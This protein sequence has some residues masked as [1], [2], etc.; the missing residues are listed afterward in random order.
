MPSYLSLSPVAAA[1]YARLNVAGMQALVGTRIHDSR[2]RASAY[3]C[4]WVE[5]REQKLHMMGPNS[6]PNVDI[7]VHAF[8]KYQGEKEC[9]AICA[10][11]VELLEWQTLT[12][13]GY[14]QAGDLRHHDTAPL[15]DQAIEGEV[16]HE[17]VAQ[18]QT[19]VVAA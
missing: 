2:P 9:Q 10:K 3:P 18:F 15:Q 11:A 14:V 5:V 13:S 17:M 6:V 7:W 8:S 12:I 16:V 19:R 1:V 4:V